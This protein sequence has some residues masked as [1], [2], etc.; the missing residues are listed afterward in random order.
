MTIPDHISHR[1]IATLDNEQLTTAEAELHATF[2]A[3]EKVEKVRKGAQYVLLQGPAALVNAWQRW[4]LLSNE[5]RS[6]GL[7]AP[8]R[9]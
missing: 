7:I 1:W 9:V 4:M 8:R 3:Q 6:R 5:V 2:R